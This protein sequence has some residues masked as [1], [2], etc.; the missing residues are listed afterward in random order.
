MCLPWKAALSRREDQEQ[1]WMLAEPNRAKSR[2]REVKVDL[3]RTLQERL[4]GGA[5]RWNE[6]HSQYC[7]AYFTEMGEDP[8]S[9]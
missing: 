5:K 6:D 2:S 4:N 9:H 8:G 1:P 3:R 7:A